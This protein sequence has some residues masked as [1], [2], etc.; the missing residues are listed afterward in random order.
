[1][2]SS[3]HVVYHTLSVNW[4]KIY[5][6]YSYFCQFVYPTV[7][8]SLCECHILFQNCWIFPLT[9]VFWHGCSFFLVPVIKTKGNIVHVHWHS[10]PDY[11]TINVIGIS[12]EICPQTHLNMISCKIQG[13]KLPAE[14]LLSQLPFIKTIFY[15]Y[16]VQSNNILI[17]HNP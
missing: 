9:E 12:H 6:F 14:I 11:A 1:M 7:L 10:A 15:G 16:L 2:N 8:T 5:S 4:A 17:P 3:L 13:W